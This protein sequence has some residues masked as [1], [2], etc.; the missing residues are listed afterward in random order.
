MVDLLGVPAPSLGN[1][2]LFP[3]DVPAA[4]PALLLLAGLAGWGTRGLRHRSRA[5]APA[6]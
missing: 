2:P 4:P 1:P 5:T 6:R 3:V